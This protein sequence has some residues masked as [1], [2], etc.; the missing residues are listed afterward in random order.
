MSLIRNLCGQIRLLALALPLAAGCDS[1]P[2]K[3]PPP[4]EPRPPAGTA[5]AAAAPPAT[6]APGASQSA[7]PPA[8]LSNAE[9]A[10]TWQGSYDA[11]KGTVGLPPTVKDKTHAGDDGKAMSGP[12]KVEITISPAGEVKGKA[13]GALGDATLTGRIDDG[14]ML[15]VSWFPDDATSPNAMTGVLTGLQKE[16]A[17]HGKIRVAGPDASI[18]REAQ[19]DLKRK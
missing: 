9:L 18:V 2:D 19:I 10:G 4:P 1:H 14:G 11:K 5:S 15:G 7:A 13:S 3:S 8:L 16:G 12:G 6:G 17:I